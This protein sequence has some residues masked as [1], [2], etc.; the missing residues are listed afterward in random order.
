MLKMNTIA[1]IFSGQDMLLIF[2]IVL[3]LFGAK[4]LPELAKGMGQAVKEFNKAKDEI[5]NELNKPATEVTAQP[6]ANRQEFNPAAPATTQQPAAAPAAPAA[7]PAIAEAKPK[8]ES[9]EVS[10]RP[11]L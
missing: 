9:P 10:S 5:Q 6:A 8:E 3:I 2:L 11:L 7:A 4:K 1:T